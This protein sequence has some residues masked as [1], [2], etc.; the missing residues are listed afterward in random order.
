MQFSK[1]CST[2]V[3]GLMLMCLVSP[4]G[5]VFAQSVASGT[6]EVTVADPTGSVVVGAKVGIR[7]PITG[8]NQARSGRPS[9]HEVTETFNQRFQAFR[10]GTADG[11]WLTPDIRA[12]RS[13]KAAAPWVTIAWPG[14]LAY[15]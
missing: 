9:G 2:A 1:P 11:S 15:G 7:N 6:I 13:D 12:N 14:G 5:S 4:A 8:Y 3:I 10:K